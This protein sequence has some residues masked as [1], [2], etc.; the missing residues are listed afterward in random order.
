MMGGGRLKV[1]E[2]VVCQYFRA[3]TR[4]NISTLPSSGSFGPTWG[5]EGPRWVTQTAKS[6]VDA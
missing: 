1:A 5:G 3:A 4:P 2:I 6:D